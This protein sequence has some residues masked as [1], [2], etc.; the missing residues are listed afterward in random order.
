MLNYYVKKPNKTQ[1]MILNS[2]Y[3]LQYLIVVSSTDNSQKH[4]ILCFFECTLFS[5]PSNGN[6]AILVYSIESL[7]ILLA[8]NGNKT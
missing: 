3:V 5:K 8:I 6:T 1:L 7:S 4:I 2:F